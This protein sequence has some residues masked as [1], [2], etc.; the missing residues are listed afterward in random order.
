[1]V[2]VAEATVPRLADAVTV[3]ATIRLRVAVTDGD[4]PRLAVVIAE[5]AAPRVAEADTLLIIDELPN[6]TVDDADA[7]PKPAAGDGDTGNITSVVWEPD[8]VDELPGNPEPE[9]LDGRTLGDIIPV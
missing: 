9:E 3:I 7:E 5:V 8:G 6:A 4:E 1:M 2:P